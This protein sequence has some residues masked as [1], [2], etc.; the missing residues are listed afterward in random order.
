[1]HWLVP[2]EFFVIQ[3]YFSPGKQESFPIAGIV[4]WLVGPLLVIVVFLVLR[5]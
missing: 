4:G 5:W 1:M 3:W 2:S